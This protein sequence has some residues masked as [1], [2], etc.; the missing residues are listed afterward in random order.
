MV[1]PKYGDIKDLIKKGLTVEAQEQI[2][3]LREAAIDLQEENIEI[4]ERVQALEKALKHKNE[5]L[6]QNG[7]YWI[8]DGDN[9]DGPFC[10]KCY[11]SEQLLMR[12]FEGKA[13]IPSTEQWGIGKICR[14]CESV[15]S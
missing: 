11:D 6:F 10:Q 5:I 3:A 13:F 15:H 12:L 4:K 2:M 8:V 14:K 9:K 1:L 7:A